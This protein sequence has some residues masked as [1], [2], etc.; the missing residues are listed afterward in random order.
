M[1]RGLR[2]AFFYCSEESLLAFLCCVVPVLQ[3]EYGRFGS[4]G[5][6]KTV[7]QNLSLKAPLLTDTFRTGTLS[8][9]KIWAGTGTHHARRPEPCVSLPGMIKIFSSDEVTEAE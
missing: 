2:A 8:L 9:K 1:D 6:S 5:A 3:Y 4:L 7:I